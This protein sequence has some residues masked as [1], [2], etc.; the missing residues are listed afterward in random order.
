LDFYFTSH[1][2]PVYNDVHCTLC[3]IQPTGFRDGSHEY[4]YHSHWEYKK[5][6]ALTLGFVEDTMNIYSPLTE[7]SSYGFVG[8]NALCSWTNMRA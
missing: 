3:T 5:I 2:L 1:C 7:L 8:D 4:H 6:I